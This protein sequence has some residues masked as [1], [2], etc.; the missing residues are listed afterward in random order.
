MVRYYD[1]HEEDFWDYFVI[2]D[3]ITDGQLDFNFITESDKFTDYY[4]DESTYVEEFPTE[5]N[6]SVNSGM[7]ETHSTLT[8]G[9]VTGDYAE[10][11]VNERTG[12]SIYSYGNTSDES[13]ASY[14]SNSSYDS[15]GYDD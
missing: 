3:F 15:G 9:Y 11:D 14:D 2:L 13:E 6:Q 4:I 12:E 1:E 5:V 10:S 7:L 8:E